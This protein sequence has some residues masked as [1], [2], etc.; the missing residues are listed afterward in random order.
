M[1]NPNRQIRVNAYTTEPIVYA[2]EYMQIGYEGIEPPSIHH[3]I[4]I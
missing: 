2:D 1:N 3:R 4:P